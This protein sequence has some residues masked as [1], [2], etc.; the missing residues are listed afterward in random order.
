MNDNFE[1]Q[2]PALNHFSFQVIALPNLHSLKFRFAIRDD[3]NRPIIA[4][5]EESADWE[6]QHAVALP[7]HNACSTRKASPSAAAFPVGLRNPRSH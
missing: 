3:K 2:R 4:F 1:H 5:A 7:N 6:F